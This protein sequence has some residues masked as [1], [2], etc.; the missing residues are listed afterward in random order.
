MQQTFIQVQEDNFDQNAIY[1]WLSAEH[2]DIICR[3]SARNEFRR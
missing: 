2:S 3:K 1:Q